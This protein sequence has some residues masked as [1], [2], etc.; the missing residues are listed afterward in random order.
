MKKIYLFG[1]IVLLSMFITTPVLA[2][3]STPQPTPA[4]IGVTTAPVDTYAF[5]LLGF[6]E[7]RLIGPFDSA[8]IQVSFPEE[9]TY[10][11]AGVLHLDYSLAFFGSDYIPG[12]IMNGGVL[13]VLVNSNTVASFSLDKEGD[14]SA[15]IH[16]PPLDLVSGRTDGKMEI[17]FNLTSKESCVRD[18]DVNLVIKESSYLYLPHST[19]SPVTDLTLLPRPFYQSNSL[20]D[21]TAVLV[22]PDDPTTAELQAGMDTAAG[23]GSL[24]NGG[25]ILTTTTAGKLTADQRT[26]EN[27]ILVGKA[28]SLALLTQVSLPQALENKAFKL[29]NPDDGVLQIAVSPWNSARVV[30][31]VS[32][33][34]DEGVVKSGQAV[35]YGTILT[36]AKPN[37]SIV[38]SYRTQASA[39][40][41]ATD[42]TFLELGY[43]DRNMRS[44]GTNYA[45]YEF[46]IPPGQTVS[47]DAYLELHYSHSA[48]LDFNTSG[49]TI[50]LN[51]RVISS[52]KFTEATAQ[53]N[54]VQISLPP[55]AFIQGTNQLQLQVQL[56]PSDSCTN[57]TDFVSAWA[58]I[59]S[60]ST[61][62]LPL[63]QEAAASEATLNLSGFPENLAYG[64]VQG[65]VAFI[66]PKDSPENWASAAAVAFQMGNKLDDALTQI[67]VQ[68]ADALQED[69]LAAQNVM[70]IG[71]PSQ[72][73]IVYNWKDKL[74]AP[75]EKDSNVPYD[76]A[77][78]VVYRITEGSDAGFIELFDSPWGTQKKAMLV[79]GNDANGVALAAGALAGGDFRGSL[80]GN[81]AIV[82]SGQIVSLDTRYPVGS[83]LLAAQT[84]AAQAPAT[85]KSPASS[86][87]QRK[88]LAWMIPAVI[89][90]TLLTAGVIVLK[91]LPIIKQG[92]KEESKESPA[93]KKKEPKK[94]SK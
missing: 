31:V 46:Y 19:A 89:L 35:K 40:L 48:L 30:L 78:R 56:I 73:P 59:F 90:I 58:S 64:D 36:T 12:Q 11:S 25:L 8:G 42:R 21:R 43:A 47:E 27:L 13:D 6:T 50:T 29:D 18:F 63:V 79:S 84:G 75:F 52:L 91:L 4:A 24:T 34:S 51:G 81:F 38:E 17:T 44:S 16:I 68:Y 41:A 54:K 69:L 72:L 82:S 20:F 92:K 66:L 23:F 88:N 5:P 55:S 86:E 37:L 39:P 80:A 1:W 87:I 74:P 83:E 93:E 70:L 22:L 60:D 2:Q 53:L 94:D 67:S 62:H 76:P 28:N 33:N 85:V 57:L 10:P 7:T 77:S 9:W 15:D 26:G 32:G 14:A 65:K 71:S 49:M 45:Y 61:L 3:G